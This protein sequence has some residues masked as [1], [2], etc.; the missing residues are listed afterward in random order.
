MNHEHFL[1]QTKIEIFQESDD[2][3]EVKQFSA[4][5]KS[6]LNSPK[7]EDVPEVVVRRPSTGKKNPPADP[8]D[9]GSVFPEEEA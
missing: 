5:S 7:K 8:F 6:Y 3:E 2:E 1:E 4:L 9:F